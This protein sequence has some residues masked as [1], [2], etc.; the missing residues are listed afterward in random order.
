M[1][2]RGTAGAHKLLV[3]GYMWSRKGLGKVLERACKALFII[4]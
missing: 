4:I 1:L 3:L 2:G